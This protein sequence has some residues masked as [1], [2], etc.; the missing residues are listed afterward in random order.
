MKC[1]LCGSVIKGIS[2][3]CDPF[4]LQK[5]GRCCWKCDNLRVTPARLVL[6]GVP[7]DEAKTIGENIHRA[8]RFAHKRLEQN[9]DT[10]NHN[11]SGAQVPSSSKANK[12]ARGTKAKA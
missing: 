2:F 5:R 3:S 9:A 1:C 4:P 8:V 12:R 11:N 10:T 6:V 7:V